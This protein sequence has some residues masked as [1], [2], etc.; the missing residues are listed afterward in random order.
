M[1]QVIVTMAL[2]KVFNVASAIVTVALVFVIVSNPNSAR[3]I[4]SIGSA[5]SGSLRAAMGR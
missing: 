4:E 5:F 3:V 2:D 1:K